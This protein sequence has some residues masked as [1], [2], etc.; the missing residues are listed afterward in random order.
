MPSL[1]ACQPP[2][3]ALQK[4]W[5]WGRGAGRRPIELDPECKGRL[6]PWAEGRAEPS[7]R[8]PQVQSLVSRCTCPVQFSMVKVSEGKYRVGDSNTLIFIRVNF[9]RRGWREPRGQQGPASCCG[10]SPRPEGE[11]R[12]S[13]STSSYPSEG[14]PSLPLGIPE[15]SWQ[16]W[17]ACPPLP[18]GQL[19]TAPTPIYLCLSLVRGGGLQAEEGVKGTPT[20]P[21]T[22]LVTARGLRLAAPPKSVFPAW[23][24]CGP[25]L[26]RSF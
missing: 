20:F 24:S 9:G 3:L 23:L 22:G 2:V 4:P 17:Q 13:P 5:G 1:L 15:D 18:L 12:R 7:A 19:E 11:E 6:G 8:R 10:T 26:T 25:P 16:R 21:P 14:F